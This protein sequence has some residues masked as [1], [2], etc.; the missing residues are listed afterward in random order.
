MGYDFSYNLNCKESM[1]FIDVEMN[2][3]D[4]RGSRIVYEIISLG[5]V[6]MD[7]NL[8]IV[9]SDIFHS[10][11]KPTKHTKLT[12][13]CRQITG[14]SQYMIDRAESFSNVMDK[15][16]KWVG[17][18]DS[19]LFVTWG[20]EDIRAFKRDSS[21]NRCNLKICKAIINSSSDFQK[22]LNNYWSLA[23][24]ISLKNALELYN[25]GFEGQHHNAA[26]DAL[27]TAILY[28]KYSQNSR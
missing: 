23:K 9:R 13:K 16:E 5:A 24:S 12:E 2:C 11:I 26:Y 22:E 17:D 6:K 18:M 8:N 20:D 19:T 7:G 25:L 21:I 3:D 10:F 28:G 1:V 15:F 27:N 14:I 4:R